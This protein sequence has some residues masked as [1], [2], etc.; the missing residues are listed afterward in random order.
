MGDE[1]KWRESFV[2]MN[3]LTEMMSMPNP[4][5]LILRLNDGSKIV[6]HRDDNGQVTVTK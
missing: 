2:Q 1:N 4:G 6:I 3:A 5:S